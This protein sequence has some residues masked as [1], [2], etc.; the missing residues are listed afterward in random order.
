MNNL[1]VYGSFARNDSN[2]SSDVDLLSISKDQ[3][4]K[5]IVKNN[6]NLT[7]Y[8]YLTLKKMASNGAL[9][10]YHLKEESKILYDDKFLFSELFSNSFVLKSCYAE[11][12]FFSKELLKKICKLYPDLENFKFANSKIAWCLRTHFAAIGAE[13]R[14]PIFSRNEIDKH[15][16]RIAVSLTSLKKQIYQRIEQADQA[17]KLIDSISPKLKNAD[18]SD[19][20]KKYETRVIETLKNGQYLRSLDFY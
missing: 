9:F 18:V 15:F 17:L 2:K 3:Y 10:I 20:L 12:K 14:L 19:D 6:V 8:P 7:V 5:K 1:L 16:G 13:L 4:S 11:E